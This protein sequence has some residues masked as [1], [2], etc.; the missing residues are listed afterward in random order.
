MHCQTLGQA[1]VDAGN[2]LGYVKWGPGGVPEH[3]TLI[4]HD[5]CGYLRA[6]LRSSKSHPSLDQV[7]AVHVLTH[8][9][10]HMSG[11]TT[12]SLAE[13]AAVQRDARMAELLGA[14]PTEALALA[15]TYW[16]EVYPQMSSDY[17]TGELR[18]RW[19]ASTSTSPTPPGPDPLPSRSAAARKRSRG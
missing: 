14:D 4:K 2:E 13:C 18:P 10:M 5:Q 8:E 3:K 17:I 16:R 15:R 6:Y 7:I 11:I 9:D 19:L 1:F 12:E